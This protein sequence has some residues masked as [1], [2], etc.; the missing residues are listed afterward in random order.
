MAPPPKP[1]RRGNRT[2]GG[3]AKARRGAARLAAVQALYQIGLAG[4][5]PET[6]VSEFIK[7]RLGHEVDGISYVAADPPLFISIVRGTMARLA[8]VDGM[9]AAALDPRLPFDRME[10]L[11]RSILRAGT[12]ELLANPEV[13]ARIVVTEYVEVGN[14]FYEGREPGMVNGVLDTLARR[15]RPDEMTAPPAPAP[16]AEP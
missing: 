8:D 10:L 1:T 15:L 16:D 7:L 13:P 12:W 2:G 5:E 11:L 3:S 6:V 4:A 14:A 9:V